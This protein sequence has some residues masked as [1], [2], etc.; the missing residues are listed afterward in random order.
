MRKAIISLV[1]L[2]TPLGGLAAALDELKPNAPERYTV[3]EGDTLWSIAGRY[4][5]SPWRWNELWNLNDQIRNPHRIYPGDVLVL[6]RAAPDIDAGPVTVSV[7]LEPRIRIEQRA[8]AAVPVIASRAIAPF[9]S[10]PLV[11]GERDLDSAARIVATEE[12]RVALAAGSLAYA[13]GITHEQGR[14]WQV[15]RRGAPLLDPESRT[16]LGYE[17][18]YLGEAHVRSFGKVS[19]LEIV[20]S[21]QEIYQGDRLVPLSAEVPSFG[22]QPHAPTRPVTARIVSAYGGVQEAGPLSI[23]VLSKGTRDGLEPG[24][25]L[26]LYRDPTASRGMRNEPIFGR[27]GPS[28]SDARRTYYT[29]E[30]TPRDGPLV[31]RGTAMTGENLALLP[32]ERYGLV[33]V[34]RAFDR[35]AYGIVMEAQRPV[36]LTDVLTNP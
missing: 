3:V 18:T 31:S 34:F 36:A 2:L 10:R 19:T 29:E 30:L 7:K 25:V 24:H 13:E 21:S 20:R 23:I 28:G 27:S 32:R 16:I 33:M 8:A 6:E 14:S 17:A 9:L 15:V 11:V 4:L 12:S 26:A 1:F 35:A 22:Y 5:K